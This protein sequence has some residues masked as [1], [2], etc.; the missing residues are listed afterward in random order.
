MPDLV[1][2]ADRAVTDWVI[3]RIP[4]SDPSSFWPCTTIGVVSGGRLI[5]GVVYHDWKP[6]YG[7][8]ELSMAADSP[9]W[10]KRPVI[11][12]LL[13]YPFEQLGANKAF[14]VMPLD[15]ERIL[16]TVEHIGF[17]REAVLAH[18]LGPK[19]HAVVSRMLKADYVRLYGGIHGQEVHAVGS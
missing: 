4:E 19:R 12:S 13:A 15:N 6:R 2:G 18:Q 14:V 3:E 17:T 10:A 8:I 5:A 7:T 1:A 9:L 11:K 16:K